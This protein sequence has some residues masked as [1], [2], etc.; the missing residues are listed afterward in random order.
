MWYMGLHL[1]LCS[2]WHIS[3][4]GAGLKVLPVAELS[5]ICPFSLVMLRKKTLAVPFIWHSDGYAYNRWKGMHMVTPFIDIRKLG[6]RSGLRGILELNFWNITFEVYEFS[7][8]VIAICHK[9]DLT[10]LYCLRVVVGQK[11]SMGL[12]VLKSM[13]Q[14][15][16]VPFC[17]L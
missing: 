7:I 5:V 6:G 8:A 15:D 9:L 1:C 14:P 11:S 3:Q 13:C 17:K 2:G 12:T 16:C 10:K 4:Q